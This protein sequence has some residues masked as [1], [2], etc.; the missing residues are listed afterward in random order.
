MED[1]YVRKAT[2]LGVV[3][4]DTLDVS[5]DLGFDIGYKLRVRLYGIDT[6]ERG[7]PGAAEATAWLKDKLPVGKQV[8]LQTVKDKKEKYGRY[9]A[10]VLSDSNISINDQLVAAH[11]AVPYF[12]GAKV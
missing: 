9:L 7:K 1:Q 8:T 12:G 3:D 6:P 4:G 10:T 5:L 2:V 11:L